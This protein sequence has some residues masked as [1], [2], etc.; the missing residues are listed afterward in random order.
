MNKKKYTYIDLFAGCGGLSLGLLNS[1]WTGIFAIEKSIDAFETLEHNLI[2][3]KKHYK[4]PSW[5]PKKNYDIN[6]VLNDKRKH[7]IKLKD[8]IDLVA[9]GPPCQGF[10]YAGRR[11]ESDL[12][13][14]LIDSYLN[15]IEL[16]KPK[17][18]FFENVK[19]FTLEFKNN[20]GIGKNYSVYV[21]SK[22]WDLG[23]NIH[24]RLVDFSKYGIPQKRTRFILVGV[25]K[26]LDKSDE[27]AKLFFKILEKN[28]FDF[29]KNK[30]LA[31]IVT[32]EEAISDLLEENG[33]SSCPDSV[34][35]KSGKYSKA[36]SS[37]Q[38]YLRDGKRKGSI[39]DSH[40]LVNHSQEV[41]NRFQYA[42]DNN[43][44]PKEYKIYFT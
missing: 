24:G 9:G 4:W 42:I 21:V 14:Q 1:G 16:V 27:L 19:G 12:R 29:L 2:N 23:Y 22:L 40:R 7:L 44:S 31:N 33:T 34:G 20:A 18:I 25:Q 10:S 38:K 17:F 26:E 39:P 28:K 36:Q 43:L 35:F 37:F 8:N 3:I 5:L 13:N 11:K 30:G 41:I 15:F 6:Q 32:L